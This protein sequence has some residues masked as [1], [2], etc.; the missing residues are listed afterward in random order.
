MKLN[1]YSTL[2]MALVLSIGLVFSGCSTT[3]NHAIVDKSV[4]PVVKKVEAVTPPAPAPVPAPIV[5]AEPAHQIYFE[6]DSSTLDPSAAAILDA[7]AEWL[8]ANPSTSI[9]IAGNCD[10]RGSRE[11]NLALGQ[12]RADSVKAH[13]AARGITNIETVS[14]GEEKAVCE[15]TGAACWAQNRR[16]DITI[17]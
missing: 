15:G 11:Y 1:N 8:V 3:K 16:A 17:R 10:E 2:G 13:L 12:E 6:Y 9:M 5:I 7:N 4:A 14:F